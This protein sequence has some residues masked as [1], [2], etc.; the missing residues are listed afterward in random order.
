MEIKRI[1]EYNNSLF[2]EIV[3]KQRGAFL[4]DEEL[5][6]IEIISSDSALVRGK[7]RENFKKLI[8]YFRYYSPHILNYFDEND[9][10]IISF[11]K[12]PVLTLEV[13]KIQPSQF[14]IDEDKLNALKSFIKNS[15]DI[16]IQV[17]KSDEGYI[18]VDGHTRLFIA[19]LNNFKTV[20]AIETEFDDDTNYFVS[21][22]KKRNIFT[23]K[24]L[25]L[26]SHS[27]Y[28]NLWIDF[29]DSYFNID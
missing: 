15:K 10:K 5:Y 28:K 22:A 8:E 14:Y 9:K 1:T 13:D 18:C 20:H 19:F 3:L 7:N 17:V 2:S 21:Q 26:V 16:V 6:E 4:I 29:C 12:K 23:I 11:E 24:D 25:K 27:D